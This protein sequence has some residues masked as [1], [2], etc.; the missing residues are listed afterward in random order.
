M[1]GSDN[2]KDC[3]FYIHN[4]QTADPKLWGSLTGDQNDLGFKCWRAQK[5]GCTIQAFSLVQC[6]VR[7]HP[8]P[9][10]FCR[11]NRARK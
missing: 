1:A 5:M 8:S 10:L 6:A 7:N 11:K 2:N 9:F 3:M 4:L